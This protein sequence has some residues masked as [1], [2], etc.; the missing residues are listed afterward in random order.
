MLP[1]EK[2]KPVKNGD[3][4]LRVLAPSATPPTTPRRPQRSRAAEV[5]M[6]TTKVALMVDILVRRIYDLA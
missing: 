5:H 1:S 2:A 6:L 3:G 4:T